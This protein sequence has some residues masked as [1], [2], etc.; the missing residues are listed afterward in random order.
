MAILKCPHCGSTYVE[1]TRFCNYCGAEL[2]RK[3]DKDKFLESSPFSSEELSK[4]K[5]EIERLRKENLKKEEKQKREAEKDI[6]RDKFFWFSIISFVFIVAGLIVC[7]VAPAAGVPFGN[8][9][10]SNKFN[11][12]SNAIWNSMV[13]EAFTFIL[14]LLAIAFVFVG[15]AI[16]YLFVA[17]IGPLLLTV[18]LTFA[19]IQFKMNRHWWSVA[20]FGLGILVFICGI[21]LFLIAVGA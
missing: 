12:I 11:D 14:W 5:I 6:R 4:R 7:L 19:I 10:I 13:K 9:L 17:L 2:P 1:G 15:F 8:D 20:T 18:G 21:L 3:I 16:V